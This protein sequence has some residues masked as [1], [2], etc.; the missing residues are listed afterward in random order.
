[1]E[2]LGF[3]VCVVDLE[4]ELIR[5]TAPPPS[6]RLSRRR[7]T[8]AR[9]GRSRS[10]PRG[11]GGPSR[12]S[13]DDSWAAAA[14]ARSASAASCRG[15]RPA[16]CRARSRASLPLRN[17]R[18][19]PMSDYAVAQLD[20]IEEA[21]DG[22]EPA[23]P[24]GTTSASRAFWRQRLD[25]PQRGRPDHQRAR[26]G[27]GGRERGATLPGRG[28]LAMFELDG[29]RVDALRRHLRLARPGCEADG[30]LA[31]EPETTIIAVGG[32]AGKAYEPDG[33]GC[34]PPPCPL[35]EAGEYAEAADRRPQSSCG[36]PPYANLFYNVARCE[37]LAGQKDEALDTSGVRSSS[38]SVHA[39]TR[40]TIRISIRS[41]TSPRSRSWWATP[42]SPL[43]VRRRANGQS[44]R[45]TSVP[46]PRA[47]D[48]PILP[49]VAAH[50]NPTCTP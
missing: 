43:T 37:S 8:F 19:V 2:R 17:E 35:Y 50:P 9:S 42:T 41:A 6:N 33:W 28:G 27:R 22:R 49:G 21:D 44:R 47:P 10:S 46:S 4:D 18:E 39:R 16:G 7:A 45:S 32:V 30:P 40:R 25:G 14:A 1:M 26:R 23:T 5:A 13:S 38:R 3:G 11:W 20:E 36:D 34:G 48:Q 31:E 15:A 29:D 24:S 12:S